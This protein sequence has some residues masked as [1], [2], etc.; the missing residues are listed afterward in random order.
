MGA[1]L[2]LED[3]I[4]SSEVWARISKLLFV[5]GPEALSCWGFF[6]V[7]GFLCA[8]LRLG[9]LVKPSWVKESDRSGALALE[10]SG[11]YLN[12]CS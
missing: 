10:F 3:T 7:E 6:M 12:K 8:R 1:E 5:A 4:F 11:Q 2:G 9:A